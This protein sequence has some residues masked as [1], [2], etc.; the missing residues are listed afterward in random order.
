MVGRRGSPTSTVSLNSCMSGHPR[1]AQTIAREIIQKAQMLT[2]RAH[3]GRA[4][5]PPG[6]IQ[7]SYSSSRHRALHLSIPHRS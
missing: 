6:S 5:G 4:I 2:E 3:L 7:A 1:L